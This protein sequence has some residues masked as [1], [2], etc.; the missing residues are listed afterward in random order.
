MAFG[1]RMG[2]TPNDAPKTDNRDDR[3]D[4]LIQAHSYLGAGPLP[5]TQGGATARPAGAFYERRGSNSYQ[6]AGTPI[7]DAY[8][9]AFRAAYTRL[10]G[11]QPIIWAAKAF[12]PNTGVVHMETVRQPFPVRPLTYPG[13]LPTQLQP[14]I[15]K[16]APWTQPPFN[17]TPFAPIS[18]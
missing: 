18:P 13:A 11:L 16:P 7:Q 10:G 9:T 1:F 6:E 12:K 4:P 15:A 14:T 3:I 8:S 17:F 2:A 5:T